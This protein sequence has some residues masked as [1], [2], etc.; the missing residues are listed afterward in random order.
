MALI[1]GTPA[2]AGDGTG[3][4]AADPG[5]LAEACISRGRSRVMCRSGGRPGVAGDRDHT[6]AGWHLTTLQPGRRSAW[7]EVSGQ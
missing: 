1:P 7:Q 6:R 4:M 2:S 3:A 5:K